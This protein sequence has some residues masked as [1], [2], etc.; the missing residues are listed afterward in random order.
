MSS[1]VAVAALETTGP[2][3]NRSEEVLTPRALALASLLHRELDGRRPELPAV[4]RIV[5]EGAPSTGTAPADEPSDS[6]T[7]PAY[8]RMP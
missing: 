6:P 3:G 4:G 5:D 2:T 8:E 1:S 7:Q